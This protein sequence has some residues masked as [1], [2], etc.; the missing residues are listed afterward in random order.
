MAEIDFEA[1]V[2]LGGSGFDSHTIALSLVGADHTQRIYL[3]DSFMK[4]QRLMD[5]V[6]ELIAKKGYI[7]LAFIP[8]DVEDGI[9][10]RVTM[11]ANRISAVSLLT[12]DEVGG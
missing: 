1:T 12:V 11:F 6:T 10:P 7:R 3:N 5:F 4:P 2:R 8:R 9:P